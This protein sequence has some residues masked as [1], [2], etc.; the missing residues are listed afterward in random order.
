MITKKGMFELLLKSLVAGTISIII[1]I[2]LIIVMAL[3]DS[4]LIIPIVFGIINGIIIS[5]LFKYYITVIFTMIF[6]YLSTIIISIIVFLL[7]NIIIEYIKPINLFIIS[8]F[9]NTSFHDF[10]GIF[11]LNIIGGIIYFG[12]S[13]T[14]FL[15]FLIIFYISNP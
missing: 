4:F 5:R 9:Q 13:Y 6:S 7:L 3:F 1:Y 12:L 15:I 14:I 2:F 8:M 11:T 10:I